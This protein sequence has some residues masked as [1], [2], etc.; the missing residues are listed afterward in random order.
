MP[1]RRR[2]CPPRLTVVI[3]RRF[4]FGSHGPTKAVQ[5]SGKDK[6]HIFASSGDVAISRAFVIVGNKGFIQ[7]HPDVTVRMLAALRDASD[8][9]KTDRAEA[10]KITAARN[11]MSFDMAEYIVGLYN[12]EVA[13]GDTIV[14]GA[15]VEEAWMRGKARLKGNPINSDTVVDRSYSR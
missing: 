3:F 12:F 2:N 6:V 10:V 8:F 11:K 9:M 4:S 15:K 14:S 7:S 1:V 13:L 5:I